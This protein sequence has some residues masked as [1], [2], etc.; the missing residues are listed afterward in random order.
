VPEAKTIL[1]VEDNVDDVE[2]A[3]RAFAQSRVANHVVVAR[4]GA[5]A[6]D[7]LFAEGAHQGRDVKLLPELVLLDL[8]LPRLSGLEVLRRIRADARTKLVP[9]VVLTSSVEDADLARSYGLGANSYVQKP[10]DF[11]RFLEAA[12]EL[13]LY[14][15]VV[16]HAPPRAVAGS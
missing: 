5:E 1:L 11:A 14:W 16:N 4:D 2:L 3:L 6:L 7:Y 9:V 15:L 8:Q 12:N 10:V 13:S